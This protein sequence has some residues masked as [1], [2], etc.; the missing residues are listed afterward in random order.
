MPLFLYHQSVPQAPSSEFPPLE[1]SEIHLFRNSNDVFECWGDGWP[2][3]CFINQC[4]CLSIHSFVLLSSD[5]KSSLFQTS[6]DWPLSILGSLFIFKFLIIYLIRLV[7]AFVF[8]PWTP[9]H[10]YALDLKQSV[11]I[12]KVSFKMFISKS[13]PGREL[14]RLQI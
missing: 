7:Y 10:I 6:I 5:F 3:L 8:L 9:L 12:L 14:Q 4:A 13:P 1:C 2:R 11:V